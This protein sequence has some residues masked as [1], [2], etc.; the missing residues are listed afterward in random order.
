MSIERRAFVVSPHQD[1][2]VL[3]L[4]MMLRNYDVVDIANLFTRS[5]SHI[6]PGLSE[7]VETV[8]QVRKHEEELISDIYGFKF[9][10]AGLEDSE[11][12]GVRWDDHWI[13]VDES[14]VSESQQFICDTMPRDDADIYIP[15]GFG[16]HPDHLIAHAASIRAMGQAGAKSWFIYA[17]QPYYNSPN[18]VRLRLHDT[19]S[20]ENRI[21]IPF[22]PNLKKN[23]LGYYPSQLSPERVG[24]VSAV[25]NEYIW[26]GDTG[27]GMSD[28]NDRYRQST[29]VFG[30][31]AW[32]RA[33]EL[34]Q[35][36]SK[37]DSWEIQSA[38]N[39]RIEVSTMI[40]EM[41]V[42]NEQLTAVRLEGAGWLDYADFQGAEHF[43]E[44]AWRTFVLHA[45]QT[46]ADT[47]WLSGIREDSSL[48]KTLEV[49]GQSGY[50]FAGESSFILD[51][52][53]DGYGA[54]RDSLNQKMRS[55]V[56]RLEKKKEA[57][58][59]IGGTVNIHQVDSDDIETFLNLQRL[60]AKESDGKL[61]V[62]LEDDKYCDFLRKLAQMG[63]LSSVTLRHDMAPVGMML[64]HYRDKTDGVVSIIN[65]GFDPLCSSYAPGF[66]MQLE[67][68]K[69]GHRVNAR[70][71][72]YL[73]GAEPYKRDFT[74][75]EVKLYKYIQPLGNVDTARWEGIK[76][77]GESYVE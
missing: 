53:K 49:A 15:G 46:G 31:Q 40:D 34:C 17:D 29:G 62:F 26:Q 22:A 64:F 54:W 67:L 37:H 71:I 10:D 25:G 4:G 66:I 11:V 7:D 56:R 42:D 48:Y 39:Y 57:F 32:H 61:D 27:M 74:N 38:D 9:Y 12:R 50:L 18:P 14:L 60:R 47:V 72:D 55:K 33:A 8:S 5:N 70:D 63:E 19:L 58:L 21:S 41:M 36:D 16:V 75:R 73:K 13:E 68:I 20:T 3:S 51:C 65:Q 69:M 45:E 30:S 24:Q 23:M 1:D 44:T 2:A 52:N 6:L 35:P 77:F 28:A 76:K 43:D 59:E